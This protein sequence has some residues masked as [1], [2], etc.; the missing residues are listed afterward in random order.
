MLWVREIE[1]P[2]PESHMQRALRGSP[3][4]RE[5]RGERLPEK[6]EEIGV[7]LGNWGS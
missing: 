4:V 6:A 5:Q 2:L 7:L 3:G 1:Q